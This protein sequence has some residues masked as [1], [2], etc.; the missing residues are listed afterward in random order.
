MKFSKRMDVCRAPFDKIRGVTLEVSMQLRERILFKQL[1][2]QSF[3]NTKL[4][5][6]LLI[7]QRALQTLRSCKSMLDTKDARYLAVSDGLSPL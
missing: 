2:S 7:M 1:S 3:G 5:R 6:L 4:F